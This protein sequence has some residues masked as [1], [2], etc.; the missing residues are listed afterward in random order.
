MDENRGYNS[1]LFYGIFMVGNVF[2]NIF[3]YILLNVISIV[4]I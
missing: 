1:N 4:G 2:G 3:A